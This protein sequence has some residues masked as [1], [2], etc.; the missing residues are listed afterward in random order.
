[1]KF[2]SPMLR[3]EL[4]SLP[5]LNSFAKRNDCYSCEGENSRTRSTGRLKLFIVTPFK[6]LEAYL[7]FLQMCTDV[8]IFIKFYHMN[9]TNIATHVRTKLY[10]KDQTL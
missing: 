1:M 9:S 4:L 8:D 6:S 5:C 7:V 10:D 2:V 3:K